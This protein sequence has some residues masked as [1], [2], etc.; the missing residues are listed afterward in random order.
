MPEMADW[1]HRYNAWSVSRHGLWNGCR[2]AYYYRYI[3]P[4][5]LDPK[6][7]DVPSIRA[8]KALLPKNVVKGKLIHEVIQ[9]QVDL[10]T[11]GRAVDEDAAARQYTQ[12]VGA[13]RDNARERLVE[14]HNGEEV[15]DAFF[16]CILS[17][18]S[19]QLR[20]FFG[21]V[22]PQLQCYDYLRHEEFDSF[23][24]DGAVA[25]VKL[26][27]VARS[28]D[29]G[30]IY[31]FDW[32][33]GKPNPWNADGNRLQM[34]CYVSWAI[35]H[36][37][38]R[39]KD[40]RSEMVYLSNGERVP[41]SF[42]PTQLS[43]IRDVIIRGYSEMNASYDIATFNANPSPRRCAG[44]NFSTVCP[45]SMAAKGIVLDMKDVPEDPSSSSEVEREWWRSWR[46]E[47]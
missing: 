26:D 3:A 15:E 19:R 4:A 41:F 2:R 11:T 18:G 33:T 40:I 14:H 8:L 45:H 5:L 34:G 42:H 39:P 17:D 32:K 7:I 29:D 10:I 20:V 37:G 21:Q 27:Y 35:E 31:V 36:Y 44:C 47:R 38:K 23:D 30:A 12:M 46:D 28:R 24:V 43:R 1:F 6:G 16:D 9:G 22:W 25:T 13:Y